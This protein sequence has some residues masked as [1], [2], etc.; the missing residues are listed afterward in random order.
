MAKVL[1]DP[2]VGYQSKKNAQ[3]VILDG[4]YNVKHINRLRTADDLYTYLI[5]VSWLRFLGYVLIGYVLVNIVFAFL[6]LAV[7]IQEFRAST[8]SIY[9]D[10]VRLFFFSAQTITTVGYGA[11]APNGILAGVI[12]SFEALIG[13]LSFSFITGL[14]YGRFS[15]PKARVRFSEHVIVR[16]FEDERA[17]MFRVM[18]RRANLMIEPELDVVINITDQD[19]TGAFTRQFY[20]LDLQ[21][22]KVMYLPTMWVLVH[23]IDQSSPL[24]KYS[25]QQLKK[26]DVELYILLKYYEEAFNQNLYQTHSYDFSQL[27]IDYKFGPSYTFDE[28]GYTTVDHESFQDLEKI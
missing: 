12:S 20:K 10:L 28:E 19:D 13:L 1:K 15:K 3:R 11:I 16:D 22:S 23:K 18:N 24:Y 8:G 7:G 21:R 9:E 4:K 14:L 26:L 6:Y 25:N 17:L 27:K 5:E 2:G